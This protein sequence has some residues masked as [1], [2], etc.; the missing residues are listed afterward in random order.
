MTLRQRNNISRL[1]LTTART[2][3]VA[4]TNFAVGDPKRDPRALQASECHELLNPTRTS[5]L[6]LAQRQPGKLLDQPLRT[7]YPFPPH[8]TLS[9]RPPGKNRSQKTIRSRTDCAVYCELTRSTQ[10]HC[11][12][13]EHVERF[14]LLCRQPRPVLISLSARVP[15]LQPK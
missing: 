7:L 3:I 6:I 9:L 10:A 1:Q 8:P 12:S 2:L 13:T 15:Q 14:C 11:P 4:D 5:C